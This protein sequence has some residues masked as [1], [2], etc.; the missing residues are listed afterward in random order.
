MQ[1][2]VSPVDLMLLLQCLL[3]KRAFLLAACGTVC[4]GTGGITCT[5]NGILLNS[6]FNCNST[7]FQREMYFLLQYIYNT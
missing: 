6:T 7:T 4:T 1:Y 2:R 5:L 3:L